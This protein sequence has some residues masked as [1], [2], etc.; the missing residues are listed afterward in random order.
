[1]KRS[2]VLSAALMA[3]AFGATVMA[4][5]TTELGVGGGGSPHVKTD[6]MIDGR[7]SRSPT[8]ARRSRAGRPGRTWTLRGQGMA[9]RR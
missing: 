3:A 1:M 5:K 9:H 7:T 6:W 2:F 8:A 4:Q